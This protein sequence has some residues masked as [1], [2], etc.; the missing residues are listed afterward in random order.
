MLR[1]VG[2]SQ[3]VSAIAAHT[4]TIAAIVR[5]IPHA[6]TMLVNSTVPSGAARNITALLVPN[7]RLRNASGVRSCWIVSRSGWIGPKAT[8]ATTIA[9][10]LTASGGTHRTSEK[11]STPTV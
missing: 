5:M 2:V 10:T 4:T 6:G 8:D 3:T 11:G 9:A 7:T 1:K